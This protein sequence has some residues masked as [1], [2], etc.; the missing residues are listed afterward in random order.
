MTSNCFFA[1]PFEDVRALG[2]HFVKPFG[3]LNDDGGGKVG[4]LT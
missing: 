1:S 3:G 2:F 4:K